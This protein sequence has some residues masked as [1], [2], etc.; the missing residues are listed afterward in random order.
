MD[1]DDKA[2]LIEL[3]GSERRKIVYFAETGKFPKM[4]NF[5]TIFILILC[6]TFCYST[7]PRELKFVG[8]QNRR[9]AVDTNSTTINH[10]SEKV[11]LAKCITE[12]R[13]IYLDY[14]VPKKDCYLYFTKSEEAEIDENTSVIATGWVHYRPVIFQHSGIGENKPQLNPTVVKSKTEQATTATTIIVLSSRM[15]SGV[16][17]T[18]ATA[19]THSQSNHGIQGFA[20][21]TSGRTTTVVTSQENNH[22][23]TTPVRAQST[24]SLSTSSKKE[25][26]ETSDES[27]TNGQYTTESDGDSSSGWIN[28]LQEF[29]D[30]IIGKFGNGIFETK[31]FV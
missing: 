1:G 28:V 15:T 3:F 6:A 21:S 7:C 11:C 27:S 30:H 31:S 19:D 14:Y 24:N 17:S 9:L 16:T 25:T 22:F 18:A 26:L 20:S 4:A 29:Q 23:A 8:F 13:C 12:E 2:T 10:I 5:M